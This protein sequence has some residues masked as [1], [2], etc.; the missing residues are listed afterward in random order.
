M[1]VHVCQQ[2]MSHPPLLQHVL[3][4]QREVLHLQ[5]LLFTYSDS[6]FSRMIS[7]LG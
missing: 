2:A 3:D 6:L 4:V 1:K 7:D 5:L